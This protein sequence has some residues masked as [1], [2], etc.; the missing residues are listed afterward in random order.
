MQQLYYIMYFLPLLKGCGLLYCRSTG[1]SSSSGSLK[2]AANSKLD[3]Y[4]QILEKMSVS[5][6]V[7]SLNSEDLQ[8][9]R[10]AASRILQ[11]VCTLGW[12]LI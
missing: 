4:M 6:M 11:H 7:K 2:G 9:V 10:Y 12:F 8:Q 3:S 5:S 1:H